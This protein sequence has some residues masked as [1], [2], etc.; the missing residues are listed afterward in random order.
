MQL[1]KEFRAFILIITISLIVITEAKPQLYNMTMGARANALGEASVALHDVYAAHNNQAGL[2]WLSNTTIGLHAENSF[3]LKGISVAGMA[4]A[5]PVF[6]GTFGCSATYFGMPAYNETKIGIGFG[7]KFT[8]RFAAGIQFNWQRINIPGYG[9][10]GFLGLEGG[11]QYK[12]GEHL[13]A[14]VHIYDLLRLSPEDFG[15][16]VSTQIKFGIAWEADEKLMIITEIEKGLVYNAAFRFGLEYSPTKDLFIRVGMSVA[17][18][19]FSLG[20]GYRFGSFTCN[21]AAANHPYLGFTPK[22]GIQYEF[23]K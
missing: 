17:D 19:E 5:L 2:A 9:Q 21:F 13:M 11:L 23:G 15:E 8:S 18:R 14:G 22:A 7:K 6:S 20:A 12:I 16:K 4:F 3:L 1:E 10:Y